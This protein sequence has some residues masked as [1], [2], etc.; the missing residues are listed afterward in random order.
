VET[1]LRGPKDLR[2][3][4]DL[5]DSRVAWS[6]RIIGVSSQGIPDPAVR[7]EGAAVAEADR[8]AVT[9]EPIVTVPVVAA[10]AVVASHRPIR[11]KGV[12]VEDPALASSFW[13]VAM[14]NFLEALSSSVQ[15]VTVELVDLQEEGK[16]EV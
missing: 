15:E 2:G 8:V 1:E 12:E 3:R 10:V 16:P 11:E 4:V 6:K 5:A 7:L 13:G 14:C 9:M